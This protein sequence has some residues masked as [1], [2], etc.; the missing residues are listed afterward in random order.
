MRINTP[1]EWIKAPVR[2][3]SW[4]TSEEAQKS[5]SSKRCDNKTDEHIN[6]NLNNRTIYHLMARIYTS[7]YCDENLSFSCPVSEE[8]RT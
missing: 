3:L 1:A 6:L 2:N 5:K 7:E 8:L 4:S